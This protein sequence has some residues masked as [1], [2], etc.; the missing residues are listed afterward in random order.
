MLEQSIIPGMG[1]IYADESLFL[2][3]ISPLRPAAEISV[4]ELVRLNDCIVAA[5][6]EALRPLR[7]QPPA[8]AGRTRP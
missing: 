2:A 5:F 6:T 4:D 8:K 7:R 1:N 3:G